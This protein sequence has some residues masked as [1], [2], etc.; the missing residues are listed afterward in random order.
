MIVS[1]PH[2]GTRT[3]LKVLKNHP[4][5]TPNRY[6]HFIDHAAQIRTY[7]GPVDIPLRNP[8]DILLAWQARGKDPKKAL[9]Y[10]DQM[11]DYVTNHN[12]QARL[13]KIEDFQER[14]GHVEKR[15]NGKRDRKYCEKLVQEWLTPRKRE[16]FKTYGGYEI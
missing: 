8:V 14:L 7:D 6:Y 9:T 5:L 11:I 15:Q 2:S 4:W 16:F 1:V 13:H 3:L 12:P 10:I